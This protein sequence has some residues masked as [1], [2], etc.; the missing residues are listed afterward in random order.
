M[1]TLTRQ[2]GLL[3]LMLPLALNGW[4]LGV[5]APMS[6]RAGAEPE[7]SHEVPDCHDPPASASTSMDADAQA[8][9][10]HGSCVVC[11]CSSSQFPNPVATPAPDLPHLS[12]ARASAR[13][14]ALRATPLEALF[15]P[16]IA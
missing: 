3:L 15:R 11:A 5:H 12:D 13:P 10:E 9:C 7:S 8:A 6:D 4:G 2:V 1:P 16:P 14:A